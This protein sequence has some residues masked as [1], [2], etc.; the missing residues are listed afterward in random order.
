MDILQN[1]PFIKI[2]QNCSKLPTVAPNDP[3]NDD[4]GR[5]DKTVGNLKK[6]EEEK[7]QCDYKTKRTSDLKIHK[8]VKHLRSKGNCDKCDAKFANK[9]GLDRHKQSIHQSVRYECSYCGKQFSQKPAMVMHSQIQHER[10]W[11]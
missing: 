3:I 7:H 6:I 10:T 8:K 2:T 11:S 5:S 4:I 9:S 1:D